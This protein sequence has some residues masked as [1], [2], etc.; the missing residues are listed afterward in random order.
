[1]IRTFSYRIDPNARQRQALLAGMHQTRLIRNAMRAAVAEEYQRSGK[2]LFYRDLAKLYAHPGLEHVSASTVQAIARRFSQTLEALVKARARGERRRF[3]GY[4]NGRCRT[5]IPLRQYSRPG[6]P[7][8]WRL[9]AD[10]RHL[11]IPAKLG[12]P[13]RIRLHRPLV[14]EP[15]TCCLVLHV[16]GH[17]S[18]SITCQ[19]PDPP[20]CEPCDHL[21]VG[22]DAG[23]DALVTDSAGHRVPNPRHKKVV[24][25]KL[26][27]AQRALARK[28]PGSRRWQKQ[29]AALGKLHYKV[30]RQRRDHLHK[31]ARFYAVNHNPIAIEQL[32]LRG[33]RRNRRISGALED[34]AWGMFQT[35]LTEKAEAAGHRVVKVRAAGTSQ[36]CSSCGELV[37]KTIDDRIHVCPNCGY[38]AHRDENAARNI[39]D[40]GMNGRGAAVAEREGLATRHETRT[41][42]GERHRGDLRLDSST[43][44]SRR[45]RNRREGNKSR[46]PKE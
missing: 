6:Y 18:A 26:I 44:T 27:S 24:Q 29:A 31:I 10:G 16:D 32:N 40:R 3:P 20:P 45:P 12:G 28:V 7:H 25:P 39:R 8:D 11:H 13:V 46:D 22:L 38:S 1:M 9:S 4:L 36:D 35:L 23:L 43:R 19:I 5:S 15:K 42:V 21:P 37:P 34:V 2:F 30:R 14:G 33:L 41:A 17:W